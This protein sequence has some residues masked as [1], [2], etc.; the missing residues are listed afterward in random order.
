M[1]QP[2]A[3]EAGPAAEVELDVAGRLE[4]C[5]G[6][7]ADAARRMADARERERISWED[8][9]T[10]PLATLASSA[11]GNLI[12]ERWQPRAGWAWQ[13]LLL[14]VTF[15]AG[16]TSAILYKTADASGI[17]AGNAKRSFLPDTAGMA[18]WEP[19]GLLL[20]PGH[21]LSWASAGGGVTVSGEAV[22]VR[23]GRLPDYLL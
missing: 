2:L 11:A 3:I 1:T 6:R 23:F 4:L 12:D 5:L 19:K 15:G 9:H 21:Q 7:V 10:I 13:V 22:E 20:L 14:T 18:T 8:C 16:A 17:I